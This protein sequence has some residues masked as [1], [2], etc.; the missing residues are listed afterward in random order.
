M[1]RE[2]ASVESG[3]T[4]NSFQFIYVHVNSAPQ[5]EEPPED[6]IPEEVSEGCQAP[7]AE[8]HVARLSAQIARLCASAVVRIKISKDFLIVC[9][10]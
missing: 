10:H 1:T 5:G 6:K 4:Q 8:A 2:S 3:P 7:A 9:L